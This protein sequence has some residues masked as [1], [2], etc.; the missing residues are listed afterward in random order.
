MCVR[1]RESVCVE[2]G[3]GCLVFCFIWGG[4]RGTTLSTRPLTFREPNHLKLS[5]CMTWGQKRGGGGGGGV[6]QP[7]T[8]K[9]QSGK[10][11]LIKSMNQSWEFVRE[12]GRT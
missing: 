9:Y 12:L 8:T 6:S 4:W 5:K 10:E 11:F 3:G 2:G 7:T 1:E